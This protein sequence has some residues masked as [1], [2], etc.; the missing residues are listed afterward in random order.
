MRERTDK[1]S[2]KIWKNA[3]PYERLYIEWRKTAMLL[4]EKYIPI[5]WCIQM[6]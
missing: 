6:K 2:R 5:I 4:K 1:I 3:V